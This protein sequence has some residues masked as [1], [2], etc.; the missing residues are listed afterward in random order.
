[1]TERQKAI[2]A[3]VARTLRRTGRPPSY[4]EIGRRFG[5]RSTNGVRDHLLALERQGVL[6]VGRRRG[7]ELAERARRDAFAVPLIGW[8]PAGGP[9]VSDENVEELLS[10]PDYF[11]REGE[12]FALRVRGVSM[13]GAGI[14]N[15]DV[16]VV[17]VQ[18]T[19]ESGQIGV[20]RVGTEAT[21]KRVYV[22][23]PELVLRP[24]NPS[25]HEIRVPRE[26]PE[27]RVVGRVVGLL[28]RF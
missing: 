28:R 6:A 8:V 18:P 10:L 1:V 7:I 25:M 27:V 11:G 2:F 20:V 4:R 15:G 9:A 3:F 14:M 24:E 16:V 22:R 19:I 26:S 12:L 21:V 17:R 5:I 13:I 23:G